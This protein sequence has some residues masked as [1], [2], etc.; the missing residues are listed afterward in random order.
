MT[1]LVTGG[2]GYIG[3]HVV[4]DLL[5]SGRRVVVLDDLSEGIRSRV[6]QNVALVHGTVLDA[7]AV[8]ALLKQ[9]EVTGVVHLAARKAVGESV[10]QPMLYYRENVHGAEVL[11]NACLDAG[12]SRM[13][14]SSSAAVY[15]SPSTDRVTEQSATEPESPYGRTKLAGEWL[16]SDAA[17]AHGMSAISLRYF[18]V[19]GAATPEL[20]D[21]GTKN[22]VPIALNAV[23]QGKSVEVFGDDYPTTDGTCVRDYIHVADLAGAHVAAVSALESGGLRDDVYNVGRGE[24]HSVLEVLDTVREVTG[25]E[26]ERTIVGRRAGDPAIV[27]ADPSRIRTAFGWVAK[28]DLAAM[29]DSAWAA[30]R[31]R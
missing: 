15:G 23:K 6:P 30:A 3:A 5:N 17:R 21:R 18:N 20:G 28:H 29:V 22:L 26:V 14:F 1:W 4:R 19:V 27:V 2:A 12:V 9:Y 16:V 24:G 31:L 25:L 10:E 11:V 13:L 7:D 8:A